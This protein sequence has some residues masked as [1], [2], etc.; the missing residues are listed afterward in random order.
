VSIFDSSTAGREA[1]GSRLV[2]LSGELD[3]SSVAELSQTLAMAIGR[4]DA[5]VAVDMS[6]VEFIDVAAIGVIIRADLF[7]RH[8]SRA[9]TIRSPSK[10][11]QRIL[12]LCGRKELIEVPAERPAPGLADAL[13]TW[14]AVPSAPSSTPGTAAAPEPIGVSVSAMLRALDTPTRA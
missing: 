13:A 12:E 1:G 5:E 10:C 4:G 2:V 3:L 9:L 14:V 11:V 8:R 6:A 7:L